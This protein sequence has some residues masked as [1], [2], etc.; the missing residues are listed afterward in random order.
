MILRLVL[1]NIRFRPMR[2]LLSI[3]LIGV[4]VMLILT[5]VGVS[6]GFMEDSQNRTRGVGADI[7]VKPG[8]SSFTTGNTAPLSEKLVARLAEEPHVKLATGVVQALTGNLFNSMSGIDYPAFKRM[9]GGFTFVEGDDE[10]TFRHPGEILVDTSYA[11]EQ[12][13]KLHV[14]SQTKIRNKI[15]RVCGVVETGKLGHIFVPI[16]ELQELTQATGKVSQI[17]LKLDDPKNTQNVIDSLNAL[18]PGYDILS[19][20]QVI[21]SDQCGPNP[22]RGYFYQSDY[23]DWRVYGADCRVA[24]HVYGGAA[25]DP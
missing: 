6:N 3:L 8:N 11:A 16:A 18:L 14:G 15:W 4:P 12:H 24:F 13:P 20:Q 5:L 21:D 1:E 23:R 22:S 25:E 9:S 17:Y 10:H 19:I 2:T 7:L